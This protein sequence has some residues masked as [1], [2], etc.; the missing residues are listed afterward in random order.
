MLFGISIAA[1][2][3][4]AI[5]MLIKWSKALRPFLVSTSAAPKSKDNELQTSL[6]KDRTVTWMLR[7]FQRFISFVAEAD[8]LGQVSDVS[9]K[10]PVRFPELQP[11][12]RKIFQQLHT[13]D[14]YFIFLVDVNVEFC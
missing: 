2:K 12:H 13:P 6:T 9:G 10:V 7:K 5:L 14:I 8:N 1:L 11:R 3:M 4:K